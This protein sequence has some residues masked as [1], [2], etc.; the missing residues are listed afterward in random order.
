MEANSKENGTNKSNVIIRIVGIVIHMS[1]FL[2]IAGLFFFI[3]PYFEQV[4]ED[5]GG[6]FPP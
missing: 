2:I 3:V 5:Q 1:G 6:G 4:F